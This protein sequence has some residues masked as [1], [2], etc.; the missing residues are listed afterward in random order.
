VRGSSR[1]YYPGI[2]LEGLRKTTKDIRI[3]GT[4]AEIRTGHL[5]EVLSFA[6]TCWSI[7][8]YLTQHLL[9]DATTHLQ[10][11]KGRKLRK[12]KEGTILSAFAYTIALK[13]N[14]LR[15]RAG[16]CSIN[17]LCLIRE[18]L[19]SNLGCSSGNTD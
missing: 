7:Y 15:D 12:N 1:D 13:Y 5:P 17:A 16:R 4:P 18:R 14:M 8:T 10:L 9:L 3:A 6:P 2:C 11:T 19:S